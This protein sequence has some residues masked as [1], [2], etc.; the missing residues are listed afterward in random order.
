[1]RAITFILLLFLGIQVSASGQLAEKKYIKTPTGYLMVL[2]QG[3]SVLLELELLASQEN[4]GSANF[5]GM[6][7]VDVTFGFF[8]SKTKKYNPKDFTSV[9][10]AGMHGS[11]AWKKDKPSIHA[12]GVVGDK[13]FQAYGGHILKARVST[14]S[15]EITILVHDKRLERKRDE[16][17]GADVLSL[18]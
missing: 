17:L 14:G 1:M 9:E 8:D 7:F 18:E 2:H 13:T 12:H 15:L 5:T 4:I 6:G 16:T 10:M 3:D 11:I